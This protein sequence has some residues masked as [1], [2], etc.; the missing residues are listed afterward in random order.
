MAKI[1]ITIETDEN[2]ASAY[3]VLAE[4]LEG[5]IRDTGLTGEFFHVMYY[6]FER[7]GRVA[8]TK[9]GEKCMEEIRDILIKAIQGERIDD[10][11]I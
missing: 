1:T 3:A 8:V 5:D 11:R 10:D 9:H 6:V 2:H 7:A 4:L